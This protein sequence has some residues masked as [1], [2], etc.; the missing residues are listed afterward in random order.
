ML[1]LATY[2]S[3]HAVLRAEKRLKAEGVQVELIPVPRQ[4]RSTCGFCLL[5]TLEGHEDQIH[6]SG[7]DAL[8]RVL[9]PAPGTLRRHYEPCP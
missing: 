8:W 9:E 3:S 5:L 1:V 7:A 4:I 6:G 2:P